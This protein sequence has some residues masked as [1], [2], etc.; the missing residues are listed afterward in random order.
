V[1]RDRRILYAAAFLRALA[2]GMV[3]P[4]LGVH[5]SRMGLLPGPIGV[6]V[7]LGLAGS[8]AGMLGASLWGDRGRRATLRTLAALGVAGGLGVAMGSEPALLGALAFFGMVNGMGRD[9]GGPLVLEL[10]ILPGTVS[11]SERTRTIAWYN[12]LQDAGHAVGSLLVALPAGLRALGM[13]ESASLRGALLVYVLLLGSTLGLYGLLSPAI[14]VGGRAAR[15]ART[16]LSPGS[17][18]LLF[19]ICTLF[20]F[21]SLAG[22]FLTGTLLAVF[23]QRRF[24]ASEVAIGALFFGARVLNA[25]SH[26]G[27][28]WLARRIGL[29]NTMV[30]TH[31]PASLL[32]CTVPFAPSF[33]VA[34]LLFLIREGLVEMDV[35]T[36]QSYVMAVV[37]PEERTFASGVTSL[38][39]T[40]SWAVMPSLAGVFMQ[41]LA[42]ATPLLV[43]AGMKIIYDVLL[44]HSFRRIRPPEET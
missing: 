32:L 21:D 18:R 36:R 11:E 42:L 25:L 35:P 44:W 20:A 2:V 17:K 33:G 4:L 22:G 34:A 38:V 14:E 16:R 23:F 28:A 39:R 37:R 8:A 7:A 9:R 10:A 5:L 13:G 6:I 12:V 40:A 15:A 29:V 26:L 19:R 24:G 3:A 1:N 41:S 30:F 43:G 27:A 31:I